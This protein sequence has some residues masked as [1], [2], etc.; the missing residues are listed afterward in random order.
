ME[1]IFVEWENQGPLALSCNN[2]TCYDPMLMYGGLV[3]STTFPHHKAKF[4]PAVSKEPT[5]VG[6]T[7]HPSC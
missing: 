1:L 6:T 5:A 7:Q 3:V 2:C 4:V